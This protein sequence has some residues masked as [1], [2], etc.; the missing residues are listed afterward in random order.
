LIAVRRLFSGKL[1]LLIICW[2]N[3]CAAQQLEDWARANQ[4]WLER[5]VTPNPVVPDPD[6]SRRRLLVSYDIAPEKFPAGF[7]RSATYDDA[8]AVLSFTITGQMQAA[9][10]TLDAMARLVRPDGSL[11]FSYS[12]ANNWPD[13]SDHDSALVRAGSIGWAGY[14][15]TFYLAHAPPCAADDAGCARQKLLFK[16]TAV[17]MANYLLS[18]EVT[19][20]GHPCF[21]LLRQGHGSIRLEYRPEQRD[22]IEEYQ[23]APALGFSTENNI[24]SWFFLRA[25]GQVTPESRWREA[26]DRL[27]HALLRVAWDERISQFDEGFSPGGQRDAV[28]ALD[29][30]SWGTLF[31]LAS[32]E[33]EKAQQT[34]RSVE[35]YASRDGEAAGYRPYSDERIFPGFEIGKFF[36]PNDPRKRWRDLPLVWSEGT[37]GVALAYLR[38]GHPER[39]RQ[40]ID[41][42]RPLQSVSSGLRYASRSVP[43]QMSDAP[44]VAASS[45]LVYTVGVL[46][47][48]PIAEQCWK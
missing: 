19:D 13:E 34:L 14:A 1:A 2:L 33:F 48:N 8:L 6:P 30:A 39:A 25:L 32:G 24:S 36:F 31:L 12:T 43:H 20:P 26:A 38:A 45:W 11:W 15:F 22:V 29:C 7:H 10:L 9:A 42:L 3:P 44:S 28:Q 47:G 16:N 35:T 5:Q 27:R 37:L 4:Q 21:G 46:T 17:H 23:N 41:A 40:I 18:L